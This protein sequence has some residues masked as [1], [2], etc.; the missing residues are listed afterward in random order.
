MYSFSQE[1]TTKLHALGQRKLEKGEVT[2]LAKAI[3]DLLPL[4]PSDTENISL[5]TL[6]HR[7]LIDGVIY[8]IND[9]SYIDDTT[10]QHLYNLVNAFSLWRFNT[11]HSPARVL[12]T[13]KLVTVIDDLSCL[14]RYVNVQEMCAI[15]DIADRANYFYSFFREVGECVSKQLTAA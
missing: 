7:N 5:F 1:L 13:G 6:N 3:A 8:S 10:R 14:A 4:A 9:Y 11:A 12:F 2:L 15:G